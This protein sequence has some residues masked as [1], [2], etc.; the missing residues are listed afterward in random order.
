MHYLD[1]SPDGTGPF[2]VLADVAVSGTGTYSLAELVEEADED[3]RHWDLGPGPD[4]PWRRTG[5]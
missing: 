4:R 5:R 2:S 3:L 1:D